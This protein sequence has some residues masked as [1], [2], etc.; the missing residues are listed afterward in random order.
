MSELERLRDRIEELEELLG[1][2]MP[3]PR[4]VR[5]FTPIRRA[6]LGLLR[7]RPLVT[8]EFAYRAIYGGRPESNQPADL[9]IIDQI[10]CRLNRVLKDHGIRIQCDNRTG[11]YLAAE[12]KAALD[13]LLADR[14]RASEP[15]P[16]RDRV[17]PVLH[18]LAVHRAD[19][20]D[21]GASLCL[22]PN[23]LETPRHNGAHPHSR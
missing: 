13:Q 5:G 7:R 6:L 11:Y 12:D 10:I 21:V 9:R 16:D 2:T 4:Y 15:D 19:A 1:L 22:A 18:R 17:G 23:D 3:W 14:N 20:A 8:R